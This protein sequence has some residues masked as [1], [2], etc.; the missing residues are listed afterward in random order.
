MSITPPT[1][2]FTYSLTALKGWFE[3]HALD[4]AASVDSATDPSVLPLVAG[5]CVHVSSNAYNPVNNNTKVDSTIRPGAQLTQMP[6]FLKENQTDYDVSNNGNGQSDPYGWTGITPS[7][8]AMGGPMS[9]LV[10]TGGFELATTQFDQSNGVT[11][12]PGDILTSPTEALIT[13]SDKSAAGKL[14]KICNWPG[15]SAAAAVLYT[16][17][18]CG[19]VS[20]GQ[21][22]NE[23][24]R[25]VLAFWPCYLPGTV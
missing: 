17:H 18:I 7:A 16:N 22:P 11:Y 3:Q 9:M 25:Q 15:G 21:Y 19:T 12:S 2:P 14:F 5:L 13:G 8:S 23:Y 4:F 20:R 1:Q 24:R 10:A 6:L